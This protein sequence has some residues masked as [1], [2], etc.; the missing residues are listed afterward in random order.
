MTMTARCRR[1]RRSVHWRLI[2]NSW[3]AYW[4]MQKSQPLN[5]KSKPMARR[6]ST[7]KSDLRI[8]RA[9][10]RS[11]RGLTISVLNIGKVFKTS[12]RDRARDDS[13]TRANIAGQAG[14]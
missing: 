2:A 4:L 12:Q 3:H 6:K 1:C 7:L 11:C 10:R 5:P 9:Y 14:P 13:G 8:S